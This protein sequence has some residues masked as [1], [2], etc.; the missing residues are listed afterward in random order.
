MKILIQK[1]T[2]CL[3][4]AMFINTQQASAQDWTFPYP[5]TGTPCSSCAPPGWTMISGSPDLSSLVNWIGYPHHESTGVISPVPEPTPGI[6]SFMSAMAYGGG[7]EVVTTTFTIPAPR[8]LTVYFGGFGTSISGGGPSGAE[9]GDTE[10]L[11]VNG[12]TV[13]VPIPW[14][15]GWLAVT[16]DLPAGVNT[17]TLNPGLTDDDTRHVVHISIPAEQISPCDNDLLTTVSDTE[18]CIG[19]ELTLTAES[20]SGAVV[21]WDLGAPNGIPFTPV[22]EGVITY[23]ATSEDETDCPYSVA[24]TVLPLP[25][26]YAGLD[27]EICEGEE[28]ILEG[29]G[30]GLGTY[31]WT[32]G[33]IDGD[34]FIPAATGTYTVTGTNLAGCSNTD[35]VLVTVNLLP[36][37]DAGLDL[38]ACIGYDIT[39]TGTGAGVGGIYDWSGGVVDGVAFSPGATATYTLTGTDEF[40]C[41]NT[42]DVEV[43]VHDLPIIDAGADQE[44]CEG[45]E[46]TLAGSGAG[47]G[48]YDWTGG[49]TD[50]VAFSPAVTSVYTLTGTDDNG[51]VNTD[52][53]TVTVNPSPSVDAGPDISICNGDALILAG[54]GAGVGGTYDW[55]GGVVDGVSFVPV[56]TTTYTLT[57]TGDNG[58]VNTDDITVTVNGL[59]EVI[60]STDDLLGCAPYKVQ[61]NTVS[62]GASFEWHF[63]DGTM[64]TVENPTHVYLTEGL[65]DVTLTITSAE[66]CV[67]TVMYGDYV[68]VYPAPVASF[69]F[70]SREVDLGTSTADFENTSLFSD[71]Y[72]WNFGDGSPY[73][74]VFSPSHTYPSIDNGAYTVTLIA[75]N[76][77]GCADTVTRIVQMEGLTIYY[78]PNTF[79]PDG[80][81]FNETFQ[82]V[83]SSGF[84]IYDFHMAI[85]NRW[86]EMVF[87]TY[88]AAYG[89]NGAFGNEGLV[90]DGVYIWRIDFGDSG[91]DA[92]YTREGHV[93]VIK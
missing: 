70:I 86:G 71:T 74:N 25:L 8:V 81:N 5:T 39:L 55:T 91:S 92:R 40:G 33:V 79:T 2:L 32:D 62:P 68:E 46:V 87:E 49:V 14:D 72:T 16:Y 76:S 64:S 57:G 21:T 54:T 7:T 47:G 58:C 43:I 67:T 38:I 36:P 13:S 61:F 34:P 20:I 22:D 17:I 93:T 28:A 77:I 9:P 53:V 60:F 15:G 82:P 3:F 69:N 41:V 23:T 11:L 1:I 75:E 29:A 30:A 4:F 19:E 88:N 85:Y 24:I 90:Q 42:D 51:C 50:G 27:F 59:P 31:D 10:N 35:D 89:W 12:A 83:F 84:D 56:V 37:V 52:D 45:F 80:D 73:S 18:I 6:T 66:G 63:G 48:S 65:F 44:V 78:I 26:I